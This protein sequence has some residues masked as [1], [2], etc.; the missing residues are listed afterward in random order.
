MERASMLKILLVDDEREEREGIEFLIRKYKYPLSVAQAQNGVKALEYMEHNHVDILF[1]DVKMPQ[2][3]GLELAKLVNKRYPQTKI[4]IFSAYGEFAY[5]KQALEANAVNYLLKP[6]EVEEFCQVMEEL[7]ASILEEQSQREERRQEEMQLLQNILYKMLTGAVVQSAEKER[8]EAEL[9][10]ANVGCRLVHIEFM[11]HFFLQY[12]EM[13]LN[14]AAMY[15]GDRTEYM[16]LFPD[17]A[18]VIVRE[19]KYLD[20]KTLAEQ[21]LKLSR[22]VEKFTSEGMLV[23]VGRPCHNIEEFQQEAEEIEAIQRE[24]FGFGE[25]IVWTEDGRNPKYYSTD[26]ETIRKQ[27]MMA[28]DTNQA[29]LI[30][31]FTDQLV[32][33][34][35]ASNMVSKIYVQNIFYTV[36]QAMYDKNPNICHEKILNASDIMFYAKNPREMVSFFRESIDE[37]L[38]AIEVR[39]EDESG[40]IQKIKNLVEKDYMY[41]ISLN[42]VAEKVNLA[43]AYVSYIFK[44]ETGKTLIKYIT[45]IKMEKAGRLLEEGNLKIVQIA[46]ACG[47]ENQSYFNRTFKNYFGLTPK[48]FKER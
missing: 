33:V 11:N 15:L 43:P 29:A 10:S 6:I 39:Q 44:K 19:K 35:M 24:L 34:I 46:R 36:I 21:L 4:I 48:Q 30:R 18:C 2:M 22:D 40:I 31:K 45:E 26:V 7:I 27:L 47:Y 12:E 32:E 25:L 28:V 41:D 5:A 14:F 13:F 9:F 3:N 37:M 42:D 16:N 20:R 17:E 38:S 23:T 8:A 1:S